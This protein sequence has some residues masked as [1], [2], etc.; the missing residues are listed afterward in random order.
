MGNVESGTADKI[1]L[2][3]P[4]QFS[5]RKKNWST[6][7]I[8]LFQKVPAGGGTDVFLGKGEWDSSGAVP[9]VCP[10]RGTWDRG[11]LAVLG[12]QGDNGGTMEGQQGDSKGT[13][14]GQQGLPMSGPVIL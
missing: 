7:K 4:K 11:T 3:C 12:Q 6:A 9:S 14:G 5:G 8:K 10:R 13:A 2:E 1:R